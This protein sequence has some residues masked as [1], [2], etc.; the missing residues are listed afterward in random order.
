[1]K[2]NKFIR[3]IT[4]PFWMI[5][6]ENSINM[7]LIIQM[8]IL[9]KCN[10][11]AKYQKILTKACSM[12]GIRKLKL[13]NQVKAFVKNMISSGQ[14]KI[15]NIWLKNLKKLKRDFPIQKSHLI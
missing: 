15:Q 4:Q 6:Q 7:N 2:K 10:N 11:I 14:G 12:S 1:M 9:G 3:P 8:K 5:F 13:K